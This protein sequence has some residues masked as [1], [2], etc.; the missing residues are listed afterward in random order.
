V[1]NFSPGYF[2]PGKD[3]GALAQEAEWIHSRS[4]LSG[5]KKNLLTLSGN[6]C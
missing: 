4:G 1:V 6:K 5:G 2:T 3:P